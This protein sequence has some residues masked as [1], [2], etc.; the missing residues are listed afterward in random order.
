MGEGAQRS[1]VRGPWRGCPAQ[2]G[3]RSPRSPVGA[4]VGGLRLARGLRAGSLRGPSEHCGVRPGCEH[5]RGRGPGARLQ[6][7]PPAAA[8]QR[9][10]TWGSERLRAGPRS[11]SGRRGGS[12]RGRGPT[13]W[14]EGG[15]QN[16]PAARAP[17]AASRLERLSSPHF[18]SP[19]VAAA[20]SPP[21]DPPE[22]VPPPAPPPGA[23]SPAFSSTSREKS[24]PTEGPRR[25]R[26]A[27]LQCACA[28]RTPPPPSATSAVWRRIYNPSSAPPPGAGS[29][30]PLPS[31]QSRSA[32]SSSSVGP[33]SSGWARGVRRGRWEG[34]AR[35][36]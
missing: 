9:G 25:P 30:P 7:T 22:A 18:T 24:R 2:T 27:R 5:R 20:A 13:G 17:H 34:P 3:G 35:R 19:R 33:A 1:P 14:A 32:G 31:S 10:A 11:H 16:P 12:A 6:S 4:A 21:A 29:P 15:S 36:H 23:R 26:G 28:L 8:L